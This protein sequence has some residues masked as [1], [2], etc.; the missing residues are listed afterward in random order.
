M[1]QLPAAFLLATTASVC[2]NT[3]APVVPTAT[4]ELRTAYESG[5]TFADFL[6]AAADRRALWHQNYGN[7]EV[8]GDLVARARA[9]GGRW[10][11]L[12]IAVDGCSDSVNTIPYVALLT[13]AVPGLEMRIID[14]TAG[15]AFMEARPTPDGRGATPTLVILDESF[16][17]AGCWIERPS[18][19]QA[20]ALG[21]GAEMPRGDFM[22]LKMSWYRE[23]AGHTT[24]EEVVSIL[25]AASRGEHVCGA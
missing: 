11:I 10:H 22:R 15:R 9:I 8:P 17:D 5:Q 24:V 16:A 23:D 14:S 4:D 6:A 12:A 20:W 2:G 21:E 1:I 19:L 13:E 3:P 18:P 7:G 25:E